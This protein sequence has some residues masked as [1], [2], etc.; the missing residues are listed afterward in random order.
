V[1]ESFYSMAPSVTKTLTWSLVLFLLGLGT[2]AFVV[3]PASLRVESY[4][5]SVP[6]WPP[7][8]NGLTIAVL[9][10]LHT[11]SPFNGLHKLREIV[12]RTNSAHRDLVLLAGDIVIQ[13]VVAGTFVPP[14][15][16]AE[17]LK[18][19]SDPLGVYAVLGNHDWW[20]DAN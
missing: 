5:I 14:E 15:E 1:Q 12:D 20:L 17:I 13:G 10:D 11:G 16:S 4:S 3:E 6:A 19:L 18:D 8:L 2:W 9:A 7:H